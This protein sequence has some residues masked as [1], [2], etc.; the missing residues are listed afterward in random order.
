M[1]DQTIHAV[2]GVD[3]EIK[4]GEY[5]AIMG[6][7]A[8]QIHADESDRLP[9]HA[10]QG[11]VFIN[12]HLVSEMTD[13]ELARIR[14]RNRFRF[15]DLQPAAARHGL[16][17][18]ELPLI[19]AGMSSAERSSGPSRQCGKWTWNSACCTSQ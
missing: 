16:H 8:R 6:L 9:G 10:H 2:S 17:N 13:D 5:V 18:V 14:N 1:G 7:P 4:R 15:P 11:A 3:I 12:G 19:Y